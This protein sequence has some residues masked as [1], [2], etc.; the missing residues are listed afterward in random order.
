MSNQQVSAPIG[1][2][3]GSWTSKIAVAKRGGVEIITNE[4]NFRETP[5]VVG[6]GPAERN[7][8]EAGNIKMKSNFKDTVSFPA[9]FLG[10]RPDYPLLRSEKK[11]CP[12]KCVNKD[13]RVAFEVKYQ[14]QAETVFPEQV[15]AAYLNKLKFI[16]QKNNFENKSGVLAVPAYLTQQERKALLDAAKIAEFSV[17]R[18]LNESTAVALDYGMFRKNDLDAT[19][20]RNVLFIDFGHS[21]LSTFACGFTNSEMSVLEQEYCRH[22]GCRDIDYHLFEFYRAVF[23]KSSGGSDISENKKAIVKLFE[24]IERQRK[25]LSGNIEHDLSIEY[26][27][28][29][30]DLQYTMTRDKLEELCQPIFKAVVEVLTKVR[31]SLKARNIQLHSIELIG[32]GSRIP[33]FVHLVKSVFGIDPSRTLNSSESVARGCA[34]MAAIKSPLFRVSDYALNERVYYGVKFSWNF[35]EGEKLLGL[36]SELYPEKQRK[37]IYEAGAKVPSSKTIKFTRKE[38]IEILIEY[39]PA[40]NGFSKHIGYFVTKPQ[41]PQHETFGVAFKIKYTEDGLVTFEECSLVEEWFEETKT[42]KKKDDK[43][44]DEKKEDKKEEK[45]EGEPEKMEE[46]E[47]E[48]KK[49]KKEKYTA[50]K[51]EA[52]NFDNFTQKDIDAFFAAESTM[53][54]QDRMILETYERKNELESLA[55]NWKEKLATSHA[56]YARPEEVPAILAFL[57]NEREWLYSDGQNANRG[58]YNEHIAAVKAKVAHIA[59]RYDGKE[60]LD[61]ELKLMADAFNA[62]YTA[63]N[64]LVTPQ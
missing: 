43:K 19:N 20:P 61:H 37:F 25:I 60:H 35:V 26:L 55:Y 48:V 15:F 56:P 9:R 13:D 47:F 62:N 11:F 16:L 54:N 12:A 22:I 23:E 6:Y 7:I 59:K 21:K 52:N 42:P 34:L 39:E 30:C 63:L 44:K 10:L 32:G 58:T 27:M 4:A 46:E 5:C 57:D 49:T 33:S 40:I 1:I 53:V 64:S 3:L 29:E 24:Q 17:T 31:D 14:G 51:Y 50:I 41:N 18:L 45:K 36:N 28:D 2:D 8:G 38:A